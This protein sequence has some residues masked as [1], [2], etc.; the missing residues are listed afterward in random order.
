MWFR[1]IGVVSVA[2]CSGI[3]RA[4]ARWC[5]AVGLLA[6]LTLAGCRKQAAPVPL[7]SAGGTAA[8]QPADSL[9]APSNFTL[10]PGGLIE[11]GA[12]RTGATRIGA[13]RCGA[14][15][16]VQFNSWTKSA[17]ARR[18]PP[19]DCESCHAPGSGYQSRA[20]MKNPRKAKAAGLVIPPI[21][22]CTTCH[23]RGW[24]KDML[25]LAHAHER[26]AADLLKRH[27]AD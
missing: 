26:S 25:V 19:L 7:P 16:E 23:R 8:A 27:E 21:G 1:R 22:F 14:C 5:A 6:C 13:E 2:R 18:T 12:T 9:A 3:G 17:H 10:D 24:T 20:V 11:V 15:H 4:A